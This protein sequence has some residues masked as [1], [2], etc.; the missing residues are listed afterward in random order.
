MSGRSDA[1]PSS[2]R[3]W[4][5]CILSILSLPGDGVAP[6][7]AH[8]SALGAI[9]VPADR[10]RGSAPGSEMLRSRA[11]LRSS[12]GWAHFSHQNRCKLHVKPFL[13]KIIFIIISLLNRICRVSLLQPCWWPCRERGM[14][15][16]LGWL[17]V[18]ISRAWQQLCL[19]VVH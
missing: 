9:P 4:A 11:V 19:N 18:L 14:G 6:R 17:A 12:Q 2:R 15:R 7:A 13:F 16:G 5:V 1:E 3:C 8:R 10:A